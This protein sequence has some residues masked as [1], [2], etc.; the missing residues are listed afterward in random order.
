MKFD[1]VPLA[2]LGAGP[3]AAP[4]TPPTRPL[5]ASTTVAIVGAGVTGLGAT[6]ALT[7]AGRDVTIIDRGFGQG[8]ACRSG[9]IIVGGTLI[10]PAEGFER[11][12]DDLR[13]WVLAHDVRGGLD[14]RGCLELDR[15]ARLP[16]APIDWRDDG[17]VRA[18][19]TVPGGTLDP[20]A[21]VE[22]LAAQAC[23]QGATFVDGARVTSIEPDGDAVRVETTAGTVR[24]TRVLVATD[25]TAVSAGF[26]PWPVRRLTVAVETTPASDAQLDAAGWR[27]R[28]PFYTNELPLLWGRMLPGGG[29]LVGRE[30]LD[31]GLISSRELACAIDAAALRLAARIRGLHPALVSLSVARVW[32]GPI[33]RDE[34]SVPTLARDP[35]VNGVLW[36]GGYGGHGLA[37]AFRLG[38]L[39]AEALIAPDSR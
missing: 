9:G 21:L 33:A 35:R 5:P 10:G 16:A 18:S 2:S 15:D 23:R 31:I 14:W 38:R 29:V 1:A 27:D 13:A 19:G 8:A 24:A 36:A 6:L 3:W 28:Q 20:A 39:A 17:I 32:A 30:L 25:A 22:S 34:A 26:D 4:A 12:D 11:C 7:E 37:P